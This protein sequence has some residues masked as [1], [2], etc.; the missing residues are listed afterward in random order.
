MIKPVGSNILIKEV[1][2]ENES[3]IILPDSV[4]QEQVKFEVI[5]RGASC[6]TEVQIGD[7]IQ[8]KEGAKGQYISQDRDLIVVSENMAL[9]IMNYKERS[10]TVDPGGL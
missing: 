3:G 2:A 8:L 10:G 6:T 1:K 4:Q 5:E 7:I 9:V